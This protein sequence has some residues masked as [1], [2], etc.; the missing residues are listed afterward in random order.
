[1]NTGGKSAVNF[2]FLLFFAAGAAVI[3][4]GESYF[5]PAALVGFYG[6]YVS[7]VL[8]KIDDPDLAEH[9]AETIYFIGFLY[10]LVSLAV[11]F[12]R[13]TSGFVDLSSDEQIAE[14]FFFIGVSVTTSIA[15]VVLRNMVRAGY[16]IRHP[17]NR[18]SLENSYR[19]LKDIADS[20]TKNYSDTFET[21]KVYLEERKENQAL[22]S[23]KEKEYLASLQAFTDAT[24][25][26]T[27]GLSGIQG[28]LRASV[29]SLS[30]ILYTQSESIKDLNGVSGQLAEST[31]R[32]RKNI[33]ELPVDKASEA[34]KTLAEETGELNTVIDAVISILDEKLRRAG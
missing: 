31:E 34:V 11:L 33:E 6:F 17:E 30:N 18:D 25:R 4:Y 23:E 16:M 5:I 32:I 7:I 28:D 9:Y 21:I 19:L 1:M 22:F 24:E 13:F 14:V 20:F 3:Y 10:T 26:F 2:S 27:S 12:Y 15:G 29:G 8:R